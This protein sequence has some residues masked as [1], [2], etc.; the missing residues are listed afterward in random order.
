MNG[1]RPGRSKNALGAH[2][3]RWLSWG[4][5]PPARCSTS[6]FSGDGLGF[7]SVFSMAKR[8]LNSPRVARAFAAPVADLPV[9]R[10][11]SRQLLSI[12]VAKSPL[13]AIPA[14][15]SH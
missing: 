12:A 13:S 3:S 6:D 7:F 10:L 2:A 8:R 14:L 4:R 9:E 5:F 15:N 1:V 11:E